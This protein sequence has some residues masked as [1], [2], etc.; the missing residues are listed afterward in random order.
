M[1]PPARFPEAALPDLAGRV[2]PVADAWAAGAALVAIGHRDCTTTRRTL[3]YLDRMHRRGA[4]VLAVLQDDAE[5][6][7]ALAAELSLA[8]PLLLEAD[9][10]PLAAALG[11]SSVPTLL[12]VEPG[13]SIVAASEGLRRGDLEA[14]AGRLGLAAPLFA[15]E[16]EAP[17]HKPG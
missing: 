3:P 4:R 16:D 10:Y 8:L 1:A 14:F 11:I 2:A 5:A 6:A 12:L 17:A 7:R 9:P 15:P 13:G